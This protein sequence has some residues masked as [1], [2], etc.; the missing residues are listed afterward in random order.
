MK[1]I[2]RILLIFCLLVSHFAFAEKEKPHNSE[3]TE[4]TT[5]DLSPDQWLFLGELSDEAEN[6][7]NYFFL[8][9]R[10]EA[11]LVLK[12]A[13]YHT[14]KKLEIFHYEAKVKQTDSNRLR[15]EIG[16]AYLIFNPVNVSWSLGVKGEDDQGFHLKIDVLAKHAL[17][18]N[19]KD[20]NLSFLQT[21]RV[22]GHLNLGELKDLFVSANHNWLET[23]EFKLALADEQ[24][25]CTLADGD[26]MYLSR[27]TEKKAKQKPYF[28]WLSKD[29][30]VKKSIHVRSVKQQQSQWLIES[31]FE[32]LIIDFKTTPATSIYAGFI[33]AKQKGFCILIK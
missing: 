22:I 13:L 18:N 8:V 24:V 29:G 17:A 32:K 33:E 11:E 19:N 16:D 1:C 7:F 20:R 4:V 23:K 15:W 30:Q 27:S 9:Y 10:D 26:A 31:N 25:F 14:E 21:N 28:L 2:S 12:T 5:I 3:E 6:H